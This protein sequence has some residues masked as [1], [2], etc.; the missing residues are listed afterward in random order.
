MSALETAISMLG[1]VTGQ[2]SNEEGGSARSWRTG[3]T[4]RTRDSGGGTAVA[5]LN[6]TLSL[7][8]NTI[9]AIDH[10]MSP[11]SAHHHFRPSDDVIDLT[12]GLRRPWRLDAGGAGA[13]AWRGAAYTSQLAAQRTDSVELYVK[14]PGSIIVIIII[15]Q[16]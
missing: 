3:G 12:S 6:N 5:E 11:R 13:G 15:M 4:T 1:S 8:D 9:N 2:P 10:A 14:Q 7:L 16:I